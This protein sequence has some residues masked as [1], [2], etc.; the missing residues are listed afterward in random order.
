VVA[1]WDDPHR[2]VGTVQTLVFRDLSSELEQDSLLVYI[3]SMEFLVM[4]FLLM[5]F[6][7]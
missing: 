2:D 5:A 4:L 6:W 3:I 7:S 1:Y